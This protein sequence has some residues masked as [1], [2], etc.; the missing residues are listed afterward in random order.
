MEDLYADIVT[1]RTKT[2]KQGNEFYEKAI[3]ILLETGFNLKKFGTN[4]IQLQ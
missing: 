3:L 1:P 2:I 4:D